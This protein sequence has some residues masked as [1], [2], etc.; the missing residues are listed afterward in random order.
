[1]AIRFTINNVCYE[2]DTVEEAAELQQV[3]SRKRAA[4]KAAE[5]RWNATTQTAPPA[6][7]GNIHPIA[8]A[9][10]TASPEGIGHAELAKMVGVSPSSLVPMWGHF[11]R[12][13][14]E[15]SGR[16]LKYE[17]V[18]KKQPN[19]NGSGTLYKLTKSGIELIDRIS[20][21]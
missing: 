19:P 13:I 4:K 9:L 14:E 15:T 6:L 20:K 18:L 17:D 16:Q 3:L 12:W 7:N 10:R 5:T 11:R 2:A 1:M 8:A 21:E